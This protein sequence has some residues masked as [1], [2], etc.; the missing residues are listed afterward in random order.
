MLAAVGLTAVVSRIIPGRVAVV[1]PLLQ[2]APVLLVV[3]LVLLLSPGLLLLEMLLGSLK[4]SLLG[5]RSAADV[6]ADVGSFRMV[7]SSLRSS[8]PSGKPAGYLF[9]PIQ[10]RKSS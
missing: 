8:L 5:G 1:F 2:I 7:S 10:I 6:M 3:F 4:V 9:C